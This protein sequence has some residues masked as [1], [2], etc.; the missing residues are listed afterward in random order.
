[1]V[2]SAVCCLQCVTVLNSKCLSEEQLNSLI[3]VLDKFLKEHFE[4]AEE[5]QLKRKDEDYDE[6]VEEELLEEVPL[7]GRIG[8]RLS[9]LRALYMPF[10]YNFSVASWCQL[11]LRHLTIRKACSHVILRH[12]TT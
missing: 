4:R 12:V 3:T 11:T 10:V 5:R 1:M 8:K 6:L 2:T 7:L 9:V